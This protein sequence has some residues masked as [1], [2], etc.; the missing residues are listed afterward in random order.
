MSV[1]STAVRLRSRRALRGLALLLAAALV[2]L[3]G[4]VAMSAPAQ[5]C[6]CKTGELK[7]LIPA[8]DV[9]Y[10]GV[11]QRTLSTDPEQFQVV[12]QRLFKGELESARTLVTNSGGG[13]CGLGPIEKGERWLYL[14]AADGSTN[15]CAG[16]RKLTQKDLGVVQKVLGVGERLPAPDPAVAVR[17]KVE[18]SAPEDFARLAAP[19]AAAVLLGLLGLAV[20][21]R[22]TR[23]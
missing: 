17:T 9:V 19:G 10:V 13:S 7:K 15:L 11:H 14:T 20:V 21:G 1:P 4:A 8:A 12:A 6:S 3:G 23:S 22:L 18:K 2:G 16:T 5:A